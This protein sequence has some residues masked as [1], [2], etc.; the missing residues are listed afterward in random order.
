[1]ADD[2]PARVVSVSVTITPPE[3]LSASRQAGLLAFASHCT[4]HNTLGQP[5]T[6]NIQ[7]SDRP[8]RTATE[9][10]AAPSAGNGRLLGSTAVGMGLSP[11]SSEGTQS[12]GEPTKA[13]Q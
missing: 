8:T 4:V 12:P 5:P 11:S 7:L 9:Y 3:D 2:S 6:V 13:C 10:I 1:M